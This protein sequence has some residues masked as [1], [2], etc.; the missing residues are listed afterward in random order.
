MDLITRGAGD[1]ILDAFLRGREGG[2]GEIDGGEA[3]GD[4]E[5]AEDV[6]ESGI[7]RMQLS[8]LVVV[9]LVGGNDVDR[10]GGT[11]FG[12]EEKGGENS[13]V[14]VE[15]VSEDGLS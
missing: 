4:V 12:E 15:A 2:V 10:G 14:V 1:G 13:L 3:G 11:S 7:G 9:L 6:V 5:E 8:R